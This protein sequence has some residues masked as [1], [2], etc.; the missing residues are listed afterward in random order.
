LFNY[1]RAIDLLVNKED[2]IIDK[3][4]TEY[5]L[6]LAKAFRK[7]KNDFASKLSIQKAGLYKIDSKNEDIIYDLNNEKTLIDN[8]QK[9]NEDKKFEIHRNLKFNFNTKS[10]NIKSTYKILSIDGGGTRGII[11][12]Y[13]LMEL[14]RIVRKPV[15]QMFD[16]LAGVSTGALISSCLSLP[17]QESNLLPKYKAFDVYNLYLNESKDLFKTKNNIGYF[18]GTDTKYNNDGLIFKL[19]QYIGNLKLDKCLTDI[20]IPSIRVRNYT[21]TPYCF[22]RYDAKKNPF[23]NFKLFDAVMATTAAPTYFPAHK[24]KDLGIFVDGGVQCNNPTELALNEAL[25]YG[26]KHEDVFILSL[27]TGT[28]LD[29]SLEKVYSEDLNKGWL[30]WV[31]DIH[32][33]AV[34]AQSANVNES[35]I[36][37]FSNTGFDRYYRWQ[38]WFDK[39]YKLDT[40]DKN[41]LI[42]LSYCAEEF[43]EEMQHTNE[44]SFHKLIHKLSD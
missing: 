41:D 42:N 44:E 17:N 4:R 37:R 35:I 28:Y 13:W 12:S 8:L 39:I 22:N 15:C 16:L 9:R 7:M 26:Y 33:V 11:P 20:V 23:K 1:K 31:K 34:G 5:Y 43:F 25:R 32:D 19:N 36:N 38:I 27:G 30:Y 10:S 40:C 24:I 21:T 3:F 29:S 18:F 14:E 6:Y 2:L